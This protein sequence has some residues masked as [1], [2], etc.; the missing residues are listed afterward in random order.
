[1]RHPPCAWGI[2]NAQ[3]EAYLGHDLYGKPQSHMTPLEYA[4][5]GYLWDRAERVGKEV[6]NYYQLPL[7]TEHKA[8]HTI[9]PLSEHT[10]FPNASCP[11]A[12][13]GLRR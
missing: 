4:R 7:V 6:L 12:S 8:Y 2:P 9:P 13:E 5:L 1:M 3:G 11:L 10:T